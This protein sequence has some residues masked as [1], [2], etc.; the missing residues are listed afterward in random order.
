MNR[1]KDRLEYPQPQTI[2]LYDLYGSYTMPLTDLNHFFCART[3]FEKTKQFYCD[4]MG[5]HEMPRPTFPFPT[6]GS[7]RWQDLVHLGPH[8]V[9]N[10]ACIA[11]LAARRRPRQHRGD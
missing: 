7:A 11:G 2:A 10:S 9:E 1:I 5:L 8:G 6:T 3:T 4:A